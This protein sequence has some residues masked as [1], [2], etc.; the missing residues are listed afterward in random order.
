MKKLLIYILAC[1]LNIMSFANNDHKQAYELLLLQSENPTDPFIYF[2]MAEIYYRLS[3]QE[4]PI[5]DYRELRTDLYNIG[6]FYGNSLHYAK[7]VRLKDEALQVIPHANRVP[8]YDELK[9]Y[10][11]PRIAAAKAQR[12]IVDNLYNAYYQLNNRYNL[13]LGLFAQ[14]CQSYPREKNAHLLLSEND[15][16]QLQFLLEQ[17]DSI[18]SD[19][20]A[21]Q[22]ALEQYPI[23]DYQPVFRFDKIRLYRIEGLTKTNFLQNEVIMWDFADWVK[24]FITE[25]EQIYQQYFNAI[26][27]EHIKLYEAYTQHRQTPIMID[28]VLCNRINRFDYQ[29]FLIPFIMMEQNAATAWSASST[30]ETDIVDPNKI[31]M[32]LLSVYE[33]YK[34][35]EQSKEQQ[36]IL[37]ETLNEEELVK[38][39]SLFRQWGYGSVDSIRALATTILASQKQA[40]QT[41]ENNCIRHLPDFP[42]FKEYID[43]I[44]GVV[45]KEQDITKL[46]PNLSSEIIAI[47]PIGALYMVLT[48]DLAIRIMDYQQAM[49]Q[50]PIVVTP[51][52]EPLVAAYKL[53]SNNIALITQSHIYFIDNDGTL[54]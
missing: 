7:D 3:P 4:H 48:R 18:R 19:I 35:L 51:T 29:S 17:A 46:D 11:S 10:V 12:A 26:N 44:S 6:L 21:Y 40:Y 23:R 14:F 36:Q 38:Y 1:C 13:C 28:S 34:A 25:H 41:M 15:K 16:R 24:H 8:S 30:E 22:K 20:D 52:D 2:K 53:T 43:D 42:M 39:Q 33:Q 31:K 32:A 45:I 5:E 54:K 47:L 37:K 49:I 9:A 27:Q 50:T